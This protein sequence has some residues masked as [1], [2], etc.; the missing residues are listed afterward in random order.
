MTDA[1]AFPLP[2]AIRSQDATG[3]PWTRFALFLSIA[4]SGLLLDL[5]TKRQI[6]AWLGMP[7]QGT[8]HWIV[9]GYV[10]IETAT[11]P[12][13]LFGFGKG[14][15]YVFATISVA[16]VAGIG[17]WLFV[18]RAARDRFLTIV[19]AAIV[20]GIVGNLYDRLGLW[21]PPGLPGESI[22]EVRDWV[23]FSYGRYVWPNF[24]LADTFLV[25]GAAA[26]FLKTLFT[27]PEQEPAEAS[28]DA[29][30]DRSGRKS[31]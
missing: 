2:D 27:A 29:A 3:V 10:G 1:D 12:G 28:G 14:Y 18:R 21:S 26:L 23:R 24:N 11:N 5:E 8:I 20:A 19:L 22:P 6:F 30:S 16:A 31:D 15:A 25:C 17:Y 7:G 13:A 9:D 4:L